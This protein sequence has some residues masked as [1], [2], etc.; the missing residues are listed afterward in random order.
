LILD[1][2]PTILFTVRFYHNYRAVVIGQQC[3]TTQKSGGRGGR[4][5]VVNIAMLIALVDFFAFL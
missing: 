3:Q 4:G 1:E 5:G 2:N